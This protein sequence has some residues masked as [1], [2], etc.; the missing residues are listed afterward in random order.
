MQNTNFKKW[1]ENMSSLDLLDSIPQITGATT[2][3]YWHYTTACN[4]FKKISMQ[5]LD[6]HLSNQLF[7]DVEGAWLPGEPT[8]LPLPGP[9]TYPFPMPCPIMPPPYLPTESYFFDSIVKAEGGP[10]DGVGGVP[11]T[12][13]EFL[14]FINSLWNLPSLE[15]FQVTTK[16]LAIN[17]DGQLTTVFDFFD[18]V[19]GGDWATLY[20]H[21]KLAL[22]GRKDPTVAY[23]RAQYALM[24]EGGASWESYGAAVGGAMGAAAGA[25]AT[26]GGGTYVGAA[27]GAIAGAEFGAWL[28]G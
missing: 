20:K 24:P 15:D 21:V 4:L 28:D 17:V 27:A 7:K 11:R 3:Q 19:S 25:A 23:F 2:E 12:E 8:I 26:W 1:K 6:A 5:T 13:D 16:G 10:G 18:Q 22:G 9:D 14:D